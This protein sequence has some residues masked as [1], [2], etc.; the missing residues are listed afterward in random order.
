MAGFIAAI[1]DRLARESPRII[2][3]TVQGNVRPL[4]V[5]LREREVDVIITRRLQS[6]PEDDFISEKLFDERIFVVAG[7]ENRWARRRKIDL[8]GLLEEPWI[9]PL[10]HTV[11]GRLVAEG[12][13]AKGLALPKWSL[14]SEFGA[15]A[16]FSAGNRSLSQRDARLD[17][18]FRSR[19][20][21]GESAAGEPPDND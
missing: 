13:H 5:A 14:R 4:Y 10:P 9:M 11:A 19:T 2:F 1:I 12:F 17:D 16:Q 18:A 21:A 15:T 3:N 20:A 7:L 6:T 8:S